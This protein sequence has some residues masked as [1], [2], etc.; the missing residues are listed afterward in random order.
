[1]PFGSFGST[2]VVLLAVLETEP[3]ALWESGTMVEV[4]DERLKVLARG[5]R[6]VSLSSAGGQTE[7]GEDSEVKY[8][9]FVSFQDMVVGRRQD[10]AEVSVDDGGR[11]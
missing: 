9:L 8:A 2:R 7:P 5:A 3:L 6:C 11:R 10:V 1:M 4:E